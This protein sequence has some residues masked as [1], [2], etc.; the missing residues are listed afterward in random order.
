ME[1]T[2]WSTSFFLSLA[3][4][5]LIGFEREINERKDLLTD[6]INVKVAILGL[7]SFSLV[8]G[9]GSIAGALIIPFPV[10]AAI[11]FGIF[12][13]LLLAF[14]IIDSKSTHDFGITTETALLYSFLIGFLVS[15]NI[16]PV[17]VIISVTVLLILLLSRKER[18]KRIV[19]DITHHE[20]NAFVSFAI[21]AFVILPFLPNQGYSLSDL[22]HLN[23]FAQNLEIDISQI[24]DLELFNPFKLWFIVVLITG[25]DLLGYIL[26]RILGKSGWLVASL[27]GGFVSSTATTISI[28]QESKTN[29]HHEPLLSAAIFATSVSFIPILL[30]LAVL[31]SSLFLAFF[32]ILSIVLITSFILGFYYLNKSKKTDQIKIKEK[33]ILHDHQIFDLFSALK[34]VVIFLAINIASKLS[35][36]FLGNTGFL[37]TTALG[38]LSGLDA[39][40]INT[41]Q[42]VGTKIDITLGIWGLLLANSIN[43]FAKTAYCYLQGHKSFATRYFT[44]M[45]IIVGVSIFAVILFG[46]I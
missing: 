3:L 21:L 32:P 26:E 43:L 7:R 36:I 20:V 34:F 4:G 31:N 28:A 39:V 25:V 33:D 46:Q 19:D 12:G 27:I 5:A 14:Y 42:L 24:T 16:L 1:I 9:L 29:T 13:L 40:V 6:K 17:Q 45:V 11:L 22:P 15:V 2:T 30:L 44:S 41:A 38:A 8:A 18:I 37:F 23:Q 35:L 10:M